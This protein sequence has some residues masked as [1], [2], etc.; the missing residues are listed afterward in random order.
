[1]ARSF[2]ASKA[3]VQLAFSE[4]VDP[5][6]PAQYLDVKGR[7]QENNNDWDKFLTEAYACKPKQHLLSAL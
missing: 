5:R 3:L 1:M 7:L 2:L 6:I 4:I